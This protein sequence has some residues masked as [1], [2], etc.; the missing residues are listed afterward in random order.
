M[1]KVK[2]LE[3]EVSELKTNQENMHKLLV[4]ASG[5]VNSLI[6]ASNAAFANIAVSVQNIEARREMNDKLAIRQF[7]VQSAALCCQRGEG[8]VI[9][10]ANRIYDYV[11]D[12]PSQI[13]PENLLPLVRKH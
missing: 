13:L 1:T 2:D 6:T 8:D 7:C 12:N 3:K 5:R 11:L 9:S 10:L 4:E